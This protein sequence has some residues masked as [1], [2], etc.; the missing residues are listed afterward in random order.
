MFFHFG[1]GGES[2][3]SHLFFA[4]QAFIKTYV[5]WLSIVFNTKIY[6]RCDSKELENWIP[7]TPNPTY[8]V[9][10]WGKIALYSCSYYITPTRWIGRTGLV[11]GNRICI[12]IGEYSD[13]Y[14]GDIAWNNPQS[15][16]KM[17]KTN[18]KKRT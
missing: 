16:M 8:R 14:T 6:F 9:D 15:I 18:E 17:K 13:R 11:A 4:D 3:Y 12:I 1:G 2:D 7:T 5:Q 10:E